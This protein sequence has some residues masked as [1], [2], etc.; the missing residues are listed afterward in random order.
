[1]ENRNEAKINKSNIKFFAAGLLLGLLMIFAGI[2][3][4]TRTLMAAGFAVMGITVILFP[5]GTPETTKLLGYKKTKI[6]ARILGVIMIA[7]GIWI[8]MA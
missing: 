7:L 1:M 3:E 4:S 8:R 6:I 2:F 5:I